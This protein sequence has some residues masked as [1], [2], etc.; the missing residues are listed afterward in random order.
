MSKYL[1]GVDVGGTKVEAA[2]LQESDQ[3]KVSDTESVS[4][5]QNLHW[6]EKNKTFV[7]K[8][9]ERI[10]TERKNGY[11]HIVAR[12]SELLKSVLEKE[13]IS[14]DQISG[15]GFGLPGSINPRTQQ[16]SNGN[17]IALIGKNFAEDVKKSLDWSQPFLS[18]NDANCFALAEVLCGAGVEYQRKTGRNF[19][20]VTGIG[21]ILGTGCGGG[22]VIQGKVLQGKDGGA[23]EIGHIS[24]MPEGH[25]CYCGR[26]GCPEQYLSGPALEALFGTRRYS[27]VKDVF[28]SAEIFKKAEE[29]EPVA[30]AVV[31]SYRQT[32]AKF[33]G[34]LNSIFNPDF[35][36]LGGGV[37]T[38]RLIYEQIEERTKQQSYI[39]ENELTIYHSRLGDSSGVIGAALLPLL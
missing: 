26:R 1:L 14:P 9:R 27:Q 6:P 28:S 17:T 33:L 30:L 22:I 36:V 8:A 37:S 11:E 7:I 23:G 15:V 34:T 24:F 25:P 2:L 31:E 35:F 10:S 29:K 39:K 13:K 12:V 3:D 5:V 21:V 38:Q 32:L 19:S 16:M 4:S 18:E 20:E